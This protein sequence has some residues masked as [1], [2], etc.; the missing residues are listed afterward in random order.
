[1]LIGAFSNDWTL[2]IGADTR[3]YFSADPATQ[4]YAVRDRQN[5]ANSA[6]SLTHF[7]PEMNVSRDYAIVSRVVA[8]DTGRVVVTAAGITQ[9]G[10]C[11]AGEFVTS[12]AHLAEAF[13]QAPRGWRRQNMEVV[14]ETKVVAKV[15][16]PPHILAVRFW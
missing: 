5:P 14:L 4:V 11:A 3:Y 6:W 2:R 16:S 10:T 13:R 12:P 7:W 8:R 15:A 9:Y 1:M